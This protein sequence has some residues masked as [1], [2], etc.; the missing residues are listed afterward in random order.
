MLTPQPVIPLDRLLKSARE[1]LCLAHQ[2]GSSGRVNSEWISLQ[3][4]YLAQ[5]ETFIELCEVLDCGNIGGFGEGQPEHH[6]RNLY[7]RWLWLYE[8]Y[9]GSPKDAEGQYTHVQLNKAY[10]T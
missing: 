6:G 5:A 1:N 9:V 7:L 8:K 2:W 3:L 4:K 10:R